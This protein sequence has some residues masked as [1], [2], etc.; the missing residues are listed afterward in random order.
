MFAVGNRIWRRSGGASPSPSPDQEGESLNP[1]ISNVQELGSLRLALGYNVAAA[2]KG[3]DSLTDLD[4]NLRLTPTNFLNF[5]FDGGVSPG[6]WEITQGRATIA[7][8]DP[9]P[10]TRR[11]LDPDF[12]RPNTF[13]ISYRYLVNGPNGF[14][15][16]NANINLNQVLPGC[17]T[18]DC[19]NMT[20]STEYCARNPTDPR[21]P[22]A[23]NP[24]SILGDLVTGVF[25]HVTDNIL[26]NVNSTYSISTN[27]LIGVRAAVKL[28]SPCD[29]WTLTLAVN[30]TVNPAQTSFSFNFSLLGLGAQKKNTL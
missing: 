17:A 2:R 18:L 29:C 24:K 4:M 21:C 16:S 12:L 10:I 11:T 13:L 19:V 30:Q 22:G 5:A 6:S 9:R 26:T 14:L 3:A 15:A 25:Y 20:P 23:P 7:F 28:L 1:F 8:T 27:K